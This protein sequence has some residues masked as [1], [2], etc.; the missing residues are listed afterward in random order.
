MTSPG[1]V[2]V[3]AGQAA[4]VAAHALREHGYR[5]RIT[6]LGREPH[7]PY[8]RPPLS[9][10]VLVAAEE[11]SLDVLAQ[12]AWALGDIDLRSNADAVALD[13]S[14]RQVRLA[15]GQVLS[16]DT[17]LIATGGEAS[18]LACAP[19]GRPHVHYVRTLDDARRLRA[20][21][22]GKPR[23]AI[24]GGGFLGLEIASS[25][26]SAGAAVTVIE[27]ATSLLDR[28]LPAEASAWLESGLR[29]AGARLLLGTALEGVHPLPDGCTRL[30]THAGDLEADEIVVAIGLSPND[31]LARDAGLEIAAGGGVLVD[32]QCR[33]SD[34][35]V[36]A[37]GD[38]TSQQRPG[39]AAPT[40]L[41]SWQNANEQART[42]A[43]AMLGAPGPAP[44]V[45]WFWTDQGRHNIQM[46]GLPG[47]GL[48]Y[49][50]R[51]DPAAGKVLWIGHRGG[52]PLH[53]V[54]INAGADLRAI[55]P[56]F[57][58]RRPVLLDEFQRD[59]TDLRAWARQMRGDAPSTVQPPLTA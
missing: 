30:S 32:A 26:L 18:K 44:A 1:I 12:D 21:L 4:A 57:E 25:A 5:G 2:I 59:A 53:G 46:L 36:F 48:E 20:A 50:R 24:L 14:K 40:R 16:Y 52:V 41:E 47:P 42:A 39:H 3:G 56:L 23:V 17:C 34:E 7:R 10:A 11:P 58:Q 51:G 27:R 31:A 35:H 54:A 22:Q 28:F 38:C 8:E 29:Q 13:L 37:C 9:K 15:D 6:M 45:P 33:T 49:V 19:A 55:R 43:A